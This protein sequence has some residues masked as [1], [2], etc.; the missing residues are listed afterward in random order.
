MRAV[1]APLAAVAA[2][3][4]TAGTSQAALPQ[5]WAADAGD[6]IS[7]AAAPSLIVMGRSTTISGALSGTGVNFQRIDLERDEFPFDGFASE[8][9]PV[10]TD[11]DGSYSLIAN[12]TRLTRYRAVAKDRGNVTS[13]VVEVAVRYEVLFNVDDQTVRRGQ[14]VKFTGSVTP[15]VSG[16][17]VEIQRRGASGGAYRTV[18]TAALGGSSIPGR[19]VFSHRMRVRSDAS[20]RVR[21]AADEM[22]QAGTSRLRTI[23]VKGSR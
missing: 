13:A 12:P 9:A 22:N 5:A 20:Y 21:F 16:R 2:L 15:G 1:L 4:A 3:G 11:A 17:E 19:P 23:D 18:A 8:S 7:A 10:A 14:L 6:S